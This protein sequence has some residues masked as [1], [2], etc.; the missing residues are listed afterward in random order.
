M[1]VVLKDILLEKGKEWLGIDIEAH[2]LQFQPTRKDVKGDITLMVFPMAKALHLPPAEVATRLGSL[3][4][5]EVPFIQDFEVIQGFLNLVFSKT[6]WADTLHAINQTD[7]YGFADSNS[8][9]LVMVEYASPNTNKPLHLGHLRNIF[10]GYA[11]AELKK[12]NGHRVIKTQVIN[13]RGIHI[14]KSMLAWQRFAPLN[15]QGER[16][17]P[18]NTGMKG[19]KLVG[20]YYVEFEKHL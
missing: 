19:D 1:E 17:T 6:L 18:A 15:A 7:T 5:A 3:L 9:P 20:K 8:K 13:D 16:E 11:V 2:W 12:A 10:L 14:C 4:K